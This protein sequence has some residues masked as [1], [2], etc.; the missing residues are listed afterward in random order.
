MTYTVKTSSYNER[1]YGRPWLGIPQGKM[2][3]KDF[4]FVQW[5]GRPGDEGVF[6]FNAEP[7]QIVAEGQKD[8]RKGRG[9]IDGYLLCLADG[10]TVR[11]S[12]LKATPMDMRSLPN[13]GRLALAAAEMAAA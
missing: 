11:F 2:L 3:T 13:E 9:G 12:Q 7:G 10:S 1:R 6:E 8:L 5:D 4:A